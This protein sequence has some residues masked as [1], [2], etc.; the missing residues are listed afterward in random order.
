MFLSSQNSWF[1]SGWSFVL[2]NKMVDYTYKGV[3]KQ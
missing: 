1:E 3:K 2:L